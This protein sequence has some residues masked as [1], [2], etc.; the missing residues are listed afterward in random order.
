MPFYSRLYSLASTPMHHAGVY[1]LTDGWCRVGRDCV[2]GINS[3]VLLS[4][5]AAA[6]R[7]DRKKSVEKR[8]SEPPFQ[9]AIE[10]RGFHEWIVHPN[11][12]AAVDAFLDGRACESVAWS[13]GLGIRPHC[14]NL[15]SRLL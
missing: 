12:A 10:L 6:Q 3:G 4:D 11:L 13:P 15:S 5:S 14:R 9:M 1:W 8:R 2:G 7:P